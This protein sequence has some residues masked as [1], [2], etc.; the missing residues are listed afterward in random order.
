MLRWQ[1]QAHLSVGGAS[2]GFIDPVS[3]T[4]KQKEKKKIFKRSSRAG[5]IAQS[6]KL[7]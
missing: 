1:R 2:L 3:K 4:N 7:S 5:E 6:V